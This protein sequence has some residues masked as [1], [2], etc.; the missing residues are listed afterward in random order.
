MHAFKILN[1]LEKVDSLPSRE[2]EKLR[3]HEFEKWEVDKIKVWFDAAG[4]IREC[5]VAAEIHLGCSF[6]DKNEYHIAQ[7]VPELKGISYIQQYHLGPKLQRLADEQ[8]HKADYFSAEGKCKS[9]RCIFMIDD[10]KQELLV[11]MIIIPSG[12]VLK[13]NLKEIQ[14]A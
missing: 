8:M 4:I 9:G 11:K 2:I 1:A 7:F 14:N 12:P 5:N 10:V 6:V 3:N 13:R